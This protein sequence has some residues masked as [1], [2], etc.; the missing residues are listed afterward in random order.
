M[1]CLGQGPR[2]FCKFPLILNQAWR[3][4][5]PSLLMLSVFPSLPAGQ[6]VVL[7]QYDS[8]AAGLVKS[9]RDRFPKDAEVLE[10]HLLDLVQADAHYWGS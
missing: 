6:D 1:S 2:L 10:Q 9:F 3:A 7:V 4:L 8:S 5:G